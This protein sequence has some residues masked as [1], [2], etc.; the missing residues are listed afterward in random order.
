VFILD[1]NAVTQQNIQWRLFRMTT[2]LVSNYIWFSD[3]QKG[4]MREL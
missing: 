4:I 2:A 3:L 1:N